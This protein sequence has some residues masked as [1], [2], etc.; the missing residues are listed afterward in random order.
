MDAAAAEDEDEDEDEDDGLRCEDAGSVRNARGAWKEIW[1]E[2]VEEGREN[3][4][5]LDED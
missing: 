5:N 1:R 3:L 4:W 2:M